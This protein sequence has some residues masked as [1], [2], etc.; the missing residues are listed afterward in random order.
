MLRNSIP[1]CLRPS[2]NYLL[3]TAEPE[4]LG[5]GAGGLNFSKIQGKNKKFNNQSSISELQD[6]KIS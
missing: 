1:L 6:F 2:K 5:G 3:G 4:G